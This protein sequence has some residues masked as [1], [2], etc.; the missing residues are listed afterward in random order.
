MKSV[1]T[2]LCL[3]AAFASCAFGQEFITNKHNYSQFHAGTACSTAVLG[4]KLYVA[5]QPEDTTQVKILV[6]SDQRGGNLVKE[7][8]SPTEGYKY[9]FIA[10]YGDNLYV[11]FTGMDTHLNITRVQLDGNGYPKA[12]VEKRTSAES[13]D[14]GAILF[15]TPS[16]LIITWQGKNKEGA[17]VN[18]APVSLGRRKTEKRHK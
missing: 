5:F 11:A 15:A 17:Q 2:L 8:T 6:F 12:L 13:S 18:V 9:P 14:V 10:A 16:G 4:N 1:L 7:F 3:T